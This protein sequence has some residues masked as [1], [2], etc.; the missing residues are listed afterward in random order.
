MSKKNLPIIIVFILLSL[1]C[2]FAPWLIA[3]C[4]AAEANQG[5][6]TVPRQQ[7]AELKTRLEQQQTTLLTLQEEIAMLKKPSSE[8]MMS[9]NEAR[10]QLKTAQNE[11]TASN[12]SLKNA[13]ME[14]DK[15]SILCSEL[16]QQIQQEKKKA[17]LK[18]KQNA[19]WGFVAGCL[20]GCIYNNR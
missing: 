13:S 3:R 16:K 17:N 10:R 1:L 5:V 7:W 12:N 20:I 15:L 6:I 9:L 19:F 4:A 11:L 8:L 14:I 18:A 2:C